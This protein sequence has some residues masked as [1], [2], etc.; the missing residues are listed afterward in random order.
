MT[1]SQRRRQWLTRAQRGDDAAVCQ[2]IGEQ[3]SR[4]STPET[5][6]ELSAVLAAALYYGRRFVESVQTCDRALAEPG[7][8]DGWW[9]YLLS[10][11]AGSRVDLDDSDGAVTDLIDAEVALTRCDDPELELSIRKSLGASYGELSLFARAATHFL[12]ADDLD[13]RLGA[14]F[15]AGLVNALNLA[16][17]QH[18][19]AQREQQSA[20]VDDLTC[21]ARD[22]FGQAQFWLSTAVERAGNREHPWRSFMTKLE[23][24]IRTELDP[25]TGVP[26]LQELVDGGVDTG[27][28][29][30]TAVSLAVL[31]TG[32]RRLG[33][34]PEAWA[35]GRRASELLGTQNLHVSTIDEVESATHLAEVALGL[36]GAAT[37]EAALVDLGAELQRYTAGWTEAFQARLHHAL[38]DQELSRV[39]SR[40]LSD[41]L[42]GLRNRRAWE[43]WT[44]DHR[45]GPVAVVMLDIDGLKR[46]NDHHGHLAGDQLLRRFG[47]QMRR[48][49][50]PEILVARFGG[51]EFVLA[52]SGPTAAQS[53]PRLV[54]LAESALAAVDLSDLGMPTPTAATGAAVAAPGERVDG[55]LELADQR[56]YVRKNRATLDL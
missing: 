54:Q 21:A 30:T 35:A 44:R 38:A 20:G 19:W 32:L 25:Q 34:A 2:E 46:V 33:R 4:P 47:E 27:A 43:Q 17:L 9:S 52:V 40:A 31:S 41:P 49:L 11:R 1:S 16:L 26:L 42:T 18:R 50:T 5:R 3:L 22:R 6:V 45:V 13:R 28:A 23:R 56:M 53:V 51:D 15:P 8:S 24:E 37:A 10:I 39:E 7:L 48:R 36:P 55:L 14:G 12:I 29:N